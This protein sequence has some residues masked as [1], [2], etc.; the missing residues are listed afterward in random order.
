[1]Y[2]SPIEIILGEVKLQQEDGI[3]R[4]VQEQKIRV[5]K[6]ELKKALRYDRDQYRK[7]YYD[8]A[9]DLEYTIHGWISIASKRSLFDVLAYLDNRIAELTKEGV[10][11]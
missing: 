11:E 2:E 9:K 7:G 6:K 5:D 1:M 10:G 4:A 8:C 3:L